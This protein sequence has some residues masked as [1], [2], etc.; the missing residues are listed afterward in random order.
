MYGM[1]NT[2][3]N[4]MPWDHRAEISEQAVVL[5]IL[6]KYLFFNMQVGVTDMHGWIQP[7]DY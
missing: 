5:Q 4:Y 7:A 3:I 6:F 1:G 2:V